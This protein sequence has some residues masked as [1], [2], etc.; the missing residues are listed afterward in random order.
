MIVVK[1]SDKEY[2][3]PEGWNEVNLFKFE[4]ILKKNALISEY[5]SQVL[6]GLE[7]FSILIDCPVDDLKNLTKSSFETLIKETEWMKSEVVGEKKEQFVINGEV[8]KPLKD[9][10]KLTMGDNI[11]I[12]MVINESDESNLLINILPILLRKVRTIKNETG[13]LVEELESFQPEL[14]NE[15]KVLFSKEI[16]ITDVIGFRDFF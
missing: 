7:L 2:N 4:Q 12:E 15:R 5:K 8:F 3:L 13:C 16:F 10:N 9:L 14:Y 1:I 6:F 11:S